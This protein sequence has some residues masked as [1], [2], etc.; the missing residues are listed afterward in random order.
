MGANP[1]I[2]KVEIDNRITTCL[3]QESRS[4]TFS[5]NYNFSNV[6]LKAGGVK[7]NNSEFVQSLK[8]RSALSEV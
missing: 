5:G 2:E 7:R 6:S 3:A 8:K 1:E 4:Y